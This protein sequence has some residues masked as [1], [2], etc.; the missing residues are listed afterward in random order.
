[1]LNSVTQL[2]TVLEVL[3]PEATEAINLKSLLTLVVESFH[4]S[5]KIKHLHLVY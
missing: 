4:A 2:L 5:T 3:S 1:M